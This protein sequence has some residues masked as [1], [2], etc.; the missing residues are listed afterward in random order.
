MTPEE[1]ITDNESDVPDQYGMKRERSM[2]MASERHAVS[3][4]KASL[5]RR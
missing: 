3:C 1:I 5:S 4:P 2:G